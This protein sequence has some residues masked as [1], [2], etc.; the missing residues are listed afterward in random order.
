MIY[1]ESQTYYTA[2]LS[3]LFGFVLG[4]VISHYN[5]KD[6]E[7]KKWKKRKPVTFCPKC[8]ERMRAITA[9]ENEED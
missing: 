7:R 5:T 6:E 3:L 4:A 1:T 2:A 9:H 8:G